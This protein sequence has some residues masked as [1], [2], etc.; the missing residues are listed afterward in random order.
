MLTN[1]F[2]ACTLV[3]TTTSPYCTVHVQGKRSSL[4]GSFSIKPSE[5]S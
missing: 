4:S 1:I 2:V 5:P 3:R